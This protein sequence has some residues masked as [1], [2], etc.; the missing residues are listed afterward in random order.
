MNARFKEA[1]ALLAANTMMMMMIIINIAISITSIT[2]I[3]GI[4]L[5]PPTSLEVKS[6]KPHL[7]ARIRFK[8]SPLRGSYHLAWL[9]DS[10]N[11]G[12]P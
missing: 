9:S 3:T 12:K 11:L 10:V 8:P 6:R 4:T 1:R 7:E 2:C 5:H